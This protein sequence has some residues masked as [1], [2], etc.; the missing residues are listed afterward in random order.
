MIDNQKNKRNANKM[1]LTYLIGR[2][3]RET[4]LSEGRNWLLH[5]ND[6]VRTSSRIGK[7]SGI[8]SATVERASTFS[9]NLEKICENAGIK[10]QE[11]LLGNID[12]T[13]KVTFLLHSLF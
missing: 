11:I 8:G 13:M 12:A 7:S 4:K 1:T 5:Q 6:A 9:E 10:R 2:Q 3:Y